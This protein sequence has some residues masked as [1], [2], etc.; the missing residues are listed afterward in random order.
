MN[1]PQL[2]QAAVIGL[3]AVFV[4]SF[5]SAAKDGEQRRRCANLC[6]LAPDYAAR[7]RI[8]PD[9]E[10]PSLEGKTVRLSDF[11]GKVVVLNFWTKTCRP[12]LEEMPSV[13]ELAQMLAR[14]GDAVV[15][16]VTTD[17]SAQDARATL[18]SVLGGA[19]PAFVTLVDPEAEVVSGKYGT[20]LYPETWII[21]PKGVIRARFDGPRDWASPL[22][23]ELATGVASP[24]ACTVEFGPEGARG[25]GAAVCDRITG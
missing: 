8:A 14:R 23:V 9:F 1:L 22:A 12:C 10:L 15:V 24:L 16:T 17:E 2:A 21:D 6:H 7:N 18:S 3:A 4:Y 13:A 25:E 5:V 19:P 20:K 11:R